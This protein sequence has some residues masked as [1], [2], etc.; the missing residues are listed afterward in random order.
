MANDLSADP[1]I[2]DTAN[3]ANVVVQGNRFIYAL[4]WVGAT[5]AG[6]AAELQ[7]KSTSRTWW[8]GTAT[9]NGSD[10][11]TILKLAT[12]G[13]LILPT[14]GSGILYVYQGPER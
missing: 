11:W 1:L 12:P 2:L 4:H 13:D 8:K 5:T 9:G 14:L 6:H 7:V 10:V 3:A